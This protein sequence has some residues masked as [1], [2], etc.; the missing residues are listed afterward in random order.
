MAL[1]QLLESHLKLCP[2]DLLEHQAITIS[3]LVTDGEQVPPR[4]DGTML[5]HVRHGK[6]P[7]LFIHQKDHLIKPW[8]IAL[9]ELLRDGLQDIRPNQHRVS[10][11]RLDGMK[12][13]HRQL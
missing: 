3:Q 12:I 6:L 8:E 9:L 11:Y 10:H 13:M 5:R 2:L 4:A 7:I 1:E